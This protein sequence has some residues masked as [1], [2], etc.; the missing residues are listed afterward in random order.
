MLKKDLRLTYTKRRED[1]SPQTVSDLSLE[2]ANL[3]LKLPIWDHSFYHLFLPI[4]QKK[5]VDTSYI[6]SILQGKDKNI[7]L[8]KMLNDQDLINY[9]LTDS[10]VIKLNQWKVPEPLDGI[11]IPTEKIDVVILPLLAFDLNGNRIGYGKGYYDVLLSKCRPDVIKVGLS[12]FEAEKKISDVSPLDV[13][14]D[15]CVS[16][17]Q[18]YKF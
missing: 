13:P 18:I 15:Y 4:T 14:L 11:E 2:I 10:T 1:L 17:K 9:L 3:L 7:V 8:P 12:L 5:E 16:P 6:L